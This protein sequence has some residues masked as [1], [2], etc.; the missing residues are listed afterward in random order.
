MASILSRPQCTKIDLNFL[1]HPVASFTKE[2]NSRLAKRPLVFNG[3]LANRGLTSL[4]KWEK[5]NYVLFLWRNSVRQCLINSNSIR[6][7][8]ACLRNFICNAIPPRSHYFPP[9][10]VEIKRAAIAQSRRHFRIGVHV[11]HVLRIGLN[12]LRPRQG[13]VIFQTTFSN[14]FSWMK[15][16]Q[17][18]LKF[19]WS[20]FPSFKLT[21]FQHWFR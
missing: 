21:I 5:C 9:I 2:V 16:Y 19:H 18:P 14:A 8:T 11:L 20:L 13:A 12:T 1:C 4:V 15:I 3:R 10:G 7:K 6:T 17:F